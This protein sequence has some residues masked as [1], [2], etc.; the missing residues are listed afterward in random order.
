MTIARTGS[1]V[2]LGA[3]LLLAAAAPA[4]A[5]TLVSGEEAS[6]VMEIRDL[7][8]V[9]GAAFGELYNNSD[10]PLH[11]VW[12][13]IRHTWLWKNERHPKVEDNP[14]R[15]LYYKLLQPIGPGETAPFSYRPN[16]PLPERKDGR[17]ETFVEIYSFVEGE[18]VPV[19]GSEA[20]SPA[21]EEEK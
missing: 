10:Q 20:E 11:D 6:Q 2:A 18:E 14:A 21:E 13:V 4:P 17:F 1:T 12:L 19:P 9:D 8:I 7:R 16:P 5:D 15:T 3:V